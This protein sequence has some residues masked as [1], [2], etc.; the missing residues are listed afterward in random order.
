M[1]AANFST[2]STGIGTTGLVA[3]YKFLYDFP[4]EFYK[5]QGMGLM[6]QLPRHK[7]DAKL[8]KPAYL[9]DVKFAMS[10]SIIIEAMCPKIGFLTQR[11]GEYKYTMYHSAHGL[12]R[13]LE[14]CMG[15][16]DKYQAEWREQGFE[17]EYV[18]YPYTR[19]RMEGYFKSWG[20]LMKIPLSADGPPKP[21]G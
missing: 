15:E 13:T 12:D 9:T 10:S 3:M 1:N 16:W 6:S 17:H 7:A 4:R 2:F 14:V 21:A 5:I 11:F 8:D 20:E 18:P 19:E